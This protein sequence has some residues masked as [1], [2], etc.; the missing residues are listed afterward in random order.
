MKNNNKSPSTA[1]VL[2]LAGALAA[3]PMAQ[4]NDF[5][6]ARAIGEPV[7]APRTAPAPAPRDATPDLPGLGTEARAAEEPGASA[8][9][10]T[11]KWVVGIA[12]AA[13][14]VALAKG[15][16]KNGGGGTV[17]TGGDSTGGG[18]TAGGGSNGGGA[19]S[20]GG[21]LPRLPGLPGGDD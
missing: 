13:A 5:Y 16:D 9:G 19:G 7:P 12:V 1:R 8:G 17:T 18:D 3:A 14:V 2:A 11:W 4:A 10:S 20:G 21:R 15:G 6:L